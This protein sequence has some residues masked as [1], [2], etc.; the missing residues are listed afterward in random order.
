MGSIGP[1]KWDP[2]SRVGVYLGHSPINAGCVE[3][4]LKPVTWH[5]SPQYHV[6]RNE[7]FLIV[8]HMRDETIP[9]T[10]DEMC[11][12]SVESETSDEF[13]LAEL[14][15]KQLTG[16][17]EDPA[18]DPFA[19]NSGGWTLTFEGDD[20]KP[21]L[22]KNSEGGNKFAVDE[23]ARRSL[24][25]L[26]S[27]TARK[28]VSSANVQFDIPKPYLPPKNEGDHMKIPKLVNL[29]QS[30]LR[31]LE[32]VRNSQDVKEAEEYHPKKRN[33]FTAKILL[34]FYNVISKVC[35]QCTSIV[36]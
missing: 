15:F 28:G 17:S 21:N 35:T 3:L 1:P 12:N 18:I 10:W 30:G 7:T 36:M 29:S 32:R 4:I 33:A 16:T 31:R 34:S 2:R 27:M 11:K 20:N 19:A 26:S 8:S 5:L 13:D 24:P 23:I 25:N 14:C 6:V 22:T 9:P